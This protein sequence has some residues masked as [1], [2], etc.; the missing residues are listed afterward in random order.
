MATLKIEI[1]MDL[2]PVERLTK[3]IELSQNLSEKRIGE[4]LLSEFKKDEVL[5]QCY[6]DR[7]VTLSKIHEYI[8]EQA[9]QKANGHNSVMLDDDTVYGWVVHYVQDGKIENTEKLVIMQT[10]V[11]E[12][13]KEQAKKEAIEAYKNSEIRKLEEKAEAKRKAAFEKNKKKKEEIGQMSLFS[14]EDIN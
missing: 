7:K 4:F 14:L 1:S 6:Y 11:T 5:K 13:E 8:F 12:E 3:E 2:D 9:K 10:V